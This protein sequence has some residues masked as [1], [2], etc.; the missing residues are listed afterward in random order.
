MKFVTAAR[1]A[2]LPATAVL[3]GHVGRLRSRRAA[4]R[5]ADAADGDRG[6]AGAAHG[7]RLRRICRPLCRGGF[8]RNPLPAVRLSFGDPFHRRPDGEKGRS[9]FHRRPPAVRNRPRTDARQSRSGARQSLVRAGRSANAARRSCKTRPS[10]SRPTISAR[11][12]RT[13]RKPPSPRRRR[14]C[15]RPSSISTNIASCARRSTG[16]S[17][18]AAFPS[19]ISSAAAPAATPRSLATIV[20]VDPIRFEFTFDETSYLRY[21]RFAKNRKSDQSTD[22]PSAQQTGQRKRATARSAARSAG[23]GPATRRHRHRRS[24]F[25]QADRRKRFR[26]HRQDRFRR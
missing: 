4:A 13:W 15:I 12:P 25:A 6:Q 16:A 26:P 7:G 1:L 5:G 21:E 18:T 3:P 23:R 11:K 14:W 10:P 8:G 20:S 9:S 24:R 17:A 2:V 22:P 19:A